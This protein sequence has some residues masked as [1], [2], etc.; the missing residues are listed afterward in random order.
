MSR[1]R[2]AFTLIELLVVIAIIAVLL[3]LLLPAVQ[4]IRSAAARTECQNNLKQ[5]GLALHNYELNKKGLPPGRDSMGFSA[6]AYLLPFIEKENE[7]NLI[8]TSVGPLTAANAAAASMTV[9]IFLCPADPNPSPPAWGGTNYRSNQGSQIIFGLSS[10]D[11]ANANYNMP[12]P[13]GPFFLNSRIRATDITDGLSH[14]A[15]F[16]EHLKGDFSNGIASPTDTFWPQTYPATPD[17]AVSMCEAIDPNN[18]AY[19]RVSDVGAPWIYGYHS[20]TQYFHVGPP[21]GRSCMFPPGRISTT[22]TSAHDRGVNVVMCD[23]SVHFVSYGISLYTWR[24]LGSRNGKE[25]FSD[26]DW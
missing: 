20:T 19:Q 14:T 11:P 4:K 3:G 2:S 26:D 21:G 15:A 23:G 16:S 9:K 12:P 5:I 7:Q 25:P 8:N 13:N 10:T 1:S 24:A 17:E 18:L 6:H 22:A